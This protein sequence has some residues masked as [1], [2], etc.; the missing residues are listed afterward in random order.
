MPRG[1]I[2][3]SRERVSPYL[4]KVHCLLSTTESLTLIIPAQLP[5]DVRQSGNEHLVASGRRSPQTYSKAKYTLLTT[6]R[7]GI[8]SWATVTAGNDETVL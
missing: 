4:T 6:A 7:L 1:F 2:T 3:G 8:P 5:S